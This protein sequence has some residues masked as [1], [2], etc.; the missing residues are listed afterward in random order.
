MSNP[1]TYDEWW[2]LVKQH[3]RSAELLIS[4][5]T[6][7]NQGYYHAGSAA[8]AALKAYICKYKY[9]NKWPDRSDANQLYIHNLSKL[10]QISGIVLDSRSNFA[11]SWATVLQWERLRGYDLEIMS[12]TAA[13][14][15]YE[16]A[17]GVYGVVEWLRT[18]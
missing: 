8:E 2:A 9:S 4:D 10:F 3:K 16:A 14:S 1:K 6:T 15:F 5:E 11:P 7:A 13:Q 12:C 17:F 18:N